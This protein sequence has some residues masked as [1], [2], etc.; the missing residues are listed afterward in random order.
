M[1]YNVKIQSEQGKPLAGVVYFWL[2]GE[3]IGEA[4]ISA[5]GSTLSDEE[6]EQADH[7]TVESPG[8]YFLGISSLYNDTV[9][10]L[11]QKPHSALVAVLAA[12]VAGFVLSKFVKFKI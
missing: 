1:P 9:F 12:A 5:G 4:G 2:N 11:T 7:Y 6:V 8:Y 3:Q 10:T